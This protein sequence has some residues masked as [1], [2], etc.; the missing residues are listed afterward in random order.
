MSIS[1]H[2]SIVSAIC[3][4]ALAEPN[5]ALVFQVERLAKSLDDAGQRA[6]AKSIRALLTK[7]GRSSGMAPRKL[8]PSKGA[9]A[10][11]GEVLL[12]TTPLPADKE[13]GIRLVEVMFPEQVSGR[14]PIFPDEFVR[15]ILQIVE[16]W[17][18]VAALADAG[19][20]PT[21]SCLVVGAPGT[22]KTSMAYWLAKQLDL[23]VVLARIDAI[24]SSFLG[25]SARNINQVFSF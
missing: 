7:A 24:M 11:P 19:I 6:E 14:L 18:N 16:E 1:D 8:I 5:E 3:R 22:G 2:F 12:P 15:A 4:V 25:T 23:P 17:K 21:M 13:T 20:S 10:L 9:P